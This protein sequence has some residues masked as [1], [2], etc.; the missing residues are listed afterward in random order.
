MN[1]LQSAPGEPLPGQ[2]FSGPSLDPDDLPA[3]DLKSKIQI[4]P[5]GRINFMK[6]MLV[7]AVLFSNVVLAADAE[8]GKKTEREP[9]QIPGQAVCY[10]RSEFKSGHVDEFVQNVLNTKC[11]L[12]RAFA[13]H[14]VSESTISVCCIARQQ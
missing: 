10:N 12:T 1:G 8:T 6:T 13:F 3:L 7:L 5:D 9:A 4:S 11:D 2:A 14:G